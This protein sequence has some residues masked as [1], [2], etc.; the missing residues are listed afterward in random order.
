MCQDSLLFTNLHL[1]RSGGC[2]VLQGPWQEP[3]VTSVLAR[4]SRRTS[5]NYYCIGGDLLLAGPHAEWPPR[6]VHARHGL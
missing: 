3:Q 4:L 6:Q 1:H 5:G 2:Y